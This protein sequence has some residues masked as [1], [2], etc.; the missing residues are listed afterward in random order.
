MYMINKVLENLLGKSI[1]QRFE[2]IEVEEVRARRKAEIEAEMKN[3]GKGIQGEGVSEVTKEAMVPSIVS[4]SPIQNPR[5]ISAVSCIFEEDVEV[6]D[7]V[8]EDEEDDEEDDEEE[9]DEAKKD[10]ADDVFSASSHDDDDYGNDDDHGTSGIKVTEES[11]EEN[12]DDYLHDDANE[13]PE[14]A[15]GEGEHVDDKNVDDSE[16][17]ILRM[18]PDIEE[19]EIRH[20]YT[21]AE[22]I[23]QTH[24]DENEFK[25]DFEEELN[26]FD[27]N[28]QHEYEYK[29][30]E[31]ADNYDR[32]EVED[33]SDEESVNVDTSNFPTLVE[34]FS[35]ADIN[36]LRRKVE[37]CLKNKKIDGTSKDERRE[38]RKKWFRKDTERKFK[39]PLKFYKSDREVSLGDIISWGYLLQVNAYA[40]SIEYGVQYIAYIQDIMSLPWWDVEE[41]PKVRTLNHPVRERDV[42]TWGLIKF[43]AYKEFKHWKAHYPK[44]VRKINPVTGTEETILHIKK[45]R[46]IKNIP[47]LKND[48]IKL[49]IKIKIILIH[50]R[51]HTS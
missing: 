4:E 51:D 28:Q 11:N 39:R 24:I 33:C 7:V 49:E 42:P 10:D 14:N 12:V 40:I 43:E 35:Q 9:D 32:L 50:Q 38:E 23:K 1:E 19:G 47:L 34:F 13:E 41:L 20:T 45:P 15:E 29:Y 44:K 25:F 5:P 30:V 2:E 37:E 6:D 22:I 8:N 27:I 18:E 48:E 17:L 21:L 16:K 46:V 26:G 31:D 36:E 3:K